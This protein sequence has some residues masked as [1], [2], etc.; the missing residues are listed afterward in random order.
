MICESTGQKKFAGNFPADVDLLTLQ[1]AKFSNV[2]ITDYC[3]SRRSCSN[4]I[5]S[6]LLTNY[7]T[8]IEQFFKISLVNML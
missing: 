6:V 3:E 1:L 7:K 2:A 8:I 5:W 4:P